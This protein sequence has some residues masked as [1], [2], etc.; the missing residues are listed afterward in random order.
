MR[1]YLLEDRPKKKFSFKRAREYRRKQLVMRILQEAGGD[2]NKIK[3]ITDNLIR[4]IES[5]NF[6]FEKMKR[7]TIEDII[8][9]RKEIERLIY[10]HKRNRRFFELD[11]KDSY[12]GMVRVIKNEIEK[13]I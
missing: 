5:I 4:E 6:P 7:E 10:L 2:Y 13:I 11:V 3:T 12:K 8:Y 1:D 9:A